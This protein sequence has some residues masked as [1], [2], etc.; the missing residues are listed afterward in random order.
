MPHPQLPNW[1][2]EGSNPPRKILSLNVPSVPHQFLLGGHSVSTGRVQLDLHFDQF[3]ALDTLSFLLG[4]VVPE[5]RWLPVQ[6]SNAKLDAMTKWRPWK[7]SIPDGIR[8]SATKFS[9][10]IWNFLFDLVPE[11]PPRD[12]IVVKLTNTYVALWKRVKQNIF[13]ILSVSHSM[14]IFNKK[15]ALSLICLK[16]V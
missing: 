16:P 5:Y 8:C 11:G 15:T 9:E 10:F 1:H 14:E 2:Q 4:P 7:L 3:P 12:L 6:Q 13:H